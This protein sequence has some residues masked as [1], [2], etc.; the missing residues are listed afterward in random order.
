MPK[1]LKIIF[2]HYIFFFNIKGACQSLNC[3]H[4]ATAGSTIQGKLAD[5]Y[6]GRKKTIL[7][8]C[9]LTSLTAFLTSF[10]PNIWV[11]AF[12]R[13]SNGFARSGVGICCLVLSSEVVGRKWRGQVGQYGFFFFTLGFL[14]LPLV[15]YRTRTSWRY[16]YRILSILPLG[17]SILFVPFISES[18]RWLA[19]NGKK[20]EAMKVLNKLARLNGKKLPVDL[21]ILAGIIT[22]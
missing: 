4:M 3:F 20:E 10:S 9:L 15:A 5:A 6:L 12:L 18:P 7:L 11:Y 17:Y 1:P 13:F 2:F 8:S 21:V 16:I 22:F 19:I 14:S